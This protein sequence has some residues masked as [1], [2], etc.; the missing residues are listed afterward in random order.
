MTEF[1]TGVLIGL[2]IGLFCGALF[3]GMLWIHAMEHALDKD[4]D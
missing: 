4:D 1:E 2:A 3:V